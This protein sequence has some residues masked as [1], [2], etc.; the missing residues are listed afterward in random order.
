MNLNNLK[1]DPA[2]AAAAGGVLGLMLRTA[3]Y[4]SGFDDRGIL[5]ASH[6]L[7]LVCL[8]LTAA[9]A[10]YLA[11]Q[12]RKLPE[13]S[14]DY[15]RLRKALGLGAGCLLL[16]HAVALLRQSLAPL[17]LL[18]CALTGAAAIAMALCALGT[19][20]PAACHGLVCAAFA[21]DMLGRYRQ[22]SGNPQ[23]PD[24]VF[25]VLA[26][27]VLSLCAYQTLA[28]HTGLGKP[29]LQKFWGLLGLFLCILCLSGPEPQ[30]FY[31]SG[32]LWAAVCLLSIVPPAEEP[33]QEE[34]TDVPA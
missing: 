28:L 29:K 22:W 24:Y 2:L 27:V 7:H 6:P 34:E 19:R 5:S 4:R 23:L 15:P 33:S 9:M 18:R 11:V 25:H 26:G 3:L 10:L 32:G 30:A 16:M 14:R 1:K 12:A 31:L 17:D 13:Q 20:H 8:A 21:A